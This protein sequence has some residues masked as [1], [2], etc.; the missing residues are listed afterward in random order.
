MLCSHAIHQHQPESNTINSCNSVI[1]KSPRKQHCS[2]VLC[3]NMEEKTIVAKLTFIEDFS[4]GFKFCVGVISPIFCLLIFCLYWGIIYYEKYGH[5]PL[6]RDLSNMLFSSFC[7]SISIMFSFLIVIVTIRIIF[8]PFLTSISVFCHFITLN[9]SFYWPFVNYEI[10]I[11]KFISLCT[12]ATI[13]NINDAI[14]Y[15]ILIRTNVMCVLLLSTLI[16]ITSETSTIGHFL[17]GTAIFIQEEEIQ[18]L[19]NL[20]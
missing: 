11:Y 2:P 6:K 3:R 10:I 15:S 9:F 17:S 7:I 1:F 18:S 14:W 12:R 20:V 8:G 5:D 19:P 16:I 4:R 13:V